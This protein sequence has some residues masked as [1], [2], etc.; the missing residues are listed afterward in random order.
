M[1]KRNL[2]FYLIISSILFHLYQIKNKNT[3]FTITEKISVPY[4]LAVDITKEPRIFHKWINSYP[5]IKLEDILKEKENY[6]LSLTFLK[7]FKKTF[8]AKISFFEKEENFF[9]VFFELKNSRK[10]YKKM[11]LE[12]FE[13]KKGIL[14]LKLSLDFKFKNF[15]FNFICFVDYGLIKKIGRNFMRKL[16]NEILEQNEKRVEWEKSN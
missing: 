6:Y 9:Q 11:V 7:K 1:K 8:L 2:L 14:E 16:K 4:K 10:F 13:E 5:L 3:S 12:I 15:F